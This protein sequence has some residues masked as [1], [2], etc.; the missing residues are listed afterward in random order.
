MPMTSLTL[1]DHLAVQHIQRGKQRGGSIALVVVR[2]RPA[3]PLLQGQSWL[4]AVQSLYLALLVNANDDR[5][6]WRI[7]VQPHNIRQFLQKHRIP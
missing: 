3:S 1:A 2:V 6:L 5:F 7:Q 4:G